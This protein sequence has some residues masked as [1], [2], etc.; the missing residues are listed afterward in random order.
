MLRYATFAAPV[1]H[2]QKS[3]WTMDQAASFLILPIGD[4]ILWAGFFGAAVAYRTKPEIHKR[5]ILAA[6][7]ALAFAA[8]GRMNTSL[9]VFFLL[10]MLPMAALAIFD[11][12]ATGKVQKV[13]AIC[14]AV[15][16]IAF[17]RVLL[18]ET[19]PWLAVGRRLMAVFL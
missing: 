12:R 18:M 14:I 1:I 3:E 5:L 13:T 8:V 7:T 4:M 2:V 9:P 19:G 11:F 15:M 17:L 16:S 10:W 6:T